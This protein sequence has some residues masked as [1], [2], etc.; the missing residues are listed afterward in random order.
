[1][2]LKELFSLEI[3]KRLPK[4]KSNYNKRV[5][6]EIINKDD[7]INFVLNLTYN[8]FI[9][10]FTHKK[11]IQDMINAFNIKLDTIQ[12]EEIKKHIP[13]V[14]DFYNEMI[15]K[16]DIEYATLVIFYLFNYKRAIK[17]KQKRKK[18]H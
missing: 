15:K 16:Y 17:L 7:R 13:K 6:E 1:M 3:T 10:L 5:I 14:E 2:T 9:E 12:Y 11:N 8:D 4:L 18:N